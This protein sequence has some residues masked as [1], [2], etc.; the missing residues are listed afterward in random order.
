MRVVLDTNVLLS[1][2][3]WQKGL[4]PIYDAIRARKIIPCFTQVT[5]NELIR[6]LSYERLRKQL[7]RINITPD[8]VTKL[9]ASRSY[10]ILSN[11]QVNEISNDPS[12]NFILACAVVAQA[13]FIISGDQHLLA[14]P[15][16]QGIPI[17]S[18]RDFLQ[19]ITE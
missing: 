6:T 19:V 3:L 18:P 10:F 7:L 17:L 16:F 14:L 1:A 12:D 8:E 13:S 11:F 5:W 2:F 9:L 15:E 4:K